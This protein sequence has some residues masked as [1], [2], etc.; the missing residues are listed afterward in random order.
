MVEVRVALRKGHGVVVAPRDRKTS[1]GEQ[2]GAGAVGRDQLSGQ[3]L[4][5]GS[6]CKSQGCLKVHAAEFSVAMSWG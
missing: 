2:S 5:E 4:G 6:G 3:I 1:E